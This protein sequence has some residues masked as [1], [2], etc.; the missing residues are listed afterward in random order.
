MKCLKRKKMN[1]LRPKL[2]LQ[3]KLIQL[4]ELCQKTYCTNKKFNL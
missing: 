3:L 1:D 2:S 4:F